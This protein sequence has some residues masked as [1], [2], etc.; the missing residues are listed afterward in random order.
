MFLESSTHIEE[1]RNIE[2]H[3]NVWRRSGCFASQNLRN[4]FRIPLVIL[5]CLEISKQDTHLYCLFFVSAIATKKKPFTLWDN[6]LQLLL[7][8]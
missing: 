8:I 7:P 5:N 2:H 6:T 1:S 3:R 4:R